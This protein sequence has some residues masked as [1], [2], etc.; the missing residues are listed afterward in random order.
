MLLSSTHPESTAVSIVYAKKKEKT[1]QIAFQKDES[2]TK[3]DVYKSHSVR[4]SS[5]EPASSVSR[6]PAKRKPG[7]VRPITQ[8]K[9]LKRGGPSASSSTPVRLYVI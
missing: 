5:G 2:V 6:P 3:D 9:L 4:V 1:A 8:G 7:V